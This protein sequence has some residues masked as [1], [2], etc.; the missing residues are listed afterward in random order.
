MPT[1]Q[2][3]HEDPHMTCRGTHILDLARGQPVVDGSSRDVHE[4]AR[5]MIEIVGRSGFM[6]GTIQSVAA[7]IAAIDT[8]TGSTN[9][10]NGLTRLVIL[11]YTLI[12]ALADHPIG[13]EAMPSTPADRDVVL[14]GETIDA[15]GECRT[16][17]I[18]IP[19][20]DMQAIEAV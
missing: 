19:G 16:Q 20:P 14:M 3:I 11:G 6:I 4:S 8:R 17:Q 7:S 18:A 2:G 9:G 13:N 15:G 5:F 10:L 1:E 12:N